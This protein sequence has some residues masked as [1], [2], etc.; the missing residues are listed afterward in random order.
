MVASFIPTDDDTESR[1][2]QHEIIHHI[3]QSD[4]QIDVEPSK[5]D[6]FIKDIA[7][8]CVITHAEILKNSATGS[9]F[10]E[11]FDKVVE[12]HISFSGDYYLELI[13]QSIIQ[14]HLEVADKYNYPSI[15]F[16]AFVYYLKRD[17]E[18]EHGLD[19]VLNHEISED[20]IFSFILNKLNS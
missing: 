8:D 4:I 11:V 5:I 7:D 20:D 16:S 14:H 18:N 1:E 13:Y 19:K 3:N 10:L 6:S 2:W 17:L 9:T 12:K 15:E